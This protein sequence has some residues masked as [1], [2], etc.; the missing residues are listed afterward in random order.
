MML[1]KYFFS[2]AFGSI[3]CYGNKSM[4]IWDWLLV[5]FRS[6]Y[7]RWHA[8]RMQ[9]PGL[10]FDSYGRQLAIRQIWQE[11]KITQSAIHCLLNP[12]SCVRYFEYSY[13]FKALRERFD[14]KISELKFLD[15]SSPRLFPFFAADKLLADVVMIN[16]DETDLSVSR[17]Q[18]NYTGHPDR[19]TFHDNVST[20]SLPYSD[21]TFDIVSSIS[22]IEHINGSGDS[23]MLEEIERVLK[24]GG[25]VL[26]SF[27][28]KTVFENEYRDT[29]SYSTQNF[30]E[31]K[32]SYFFQRFYDMSAIQDRLLSVSKL[33]EFSRNYYAEDPPGWFD[34]YEKKWIQKGITITA[35]DPSY[36]VTHFFDNGNQHPTDRMGVCCMVLIN[37]NR[38]Y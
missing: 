28:V 32:E 16:P 17:A 21:D 6:G 25:L 2:H 14:E 9:L 5:G 29:A 27:P 20:T 30:N 35:K 26:L 3:Q 15:I 19:L 18:S 37:N 11:K 7:A 33:Q 34:G 4:R 8:R 38:L 24:P 10:E 1:K 12:V 36:M 31:E 22:V 13:L 23:K